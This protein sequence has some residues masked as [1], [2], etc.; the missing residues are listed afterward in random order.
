MTKSRKTKV[1]ADA[2]GWENFGWRRWVN[3]WGYH[4]N[5]L[6]AQPFVHR[7][8]YRDTHPHTHTPAD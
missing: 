1:K 8:R 6:K 2:K 5:L 7:Y 3:A 4:D